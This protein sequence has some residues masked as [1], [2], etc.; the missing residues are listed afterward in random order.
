MVTRTGPIAWVTDACGFSPL[1]G[2][3]IPCAAKTGTES[4]NRRTSARSEGRTRR[5]MRN[6]R[7]NVNAWPFFSVQ[8]GRVRRVF[9]GQTPFRYFSNQRVTATAERMRFVVLRHP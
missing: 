1:G 3:V 8:Y 4:P 9:W 7:S 6:L 2:N 5:V